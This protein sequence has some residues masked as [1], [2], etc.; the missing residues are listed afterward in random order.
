MGTLADTFASGKPPV[1]F[2]G[3]Q[4][5]EAIDKAVDQSVKGSNPPHPSSPAASAPNTGPTAKQPGPNIHPAAKGVYG[6]PVGDTI[7]K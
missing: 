7:L 3:Q 2:G 5:R 1:G 6:A 4:R